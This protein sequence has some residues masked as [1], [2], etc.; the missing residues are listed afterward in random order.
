M[1]DAD[2]GLA[3]GK[4]ADFVVVAGDT[5]TEAVITQAPRTYV[6]KN[7]QVVA[8]NGEYQGKH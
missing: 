3:E 2:Y 5:V 1:K 7:G 8:S 6:V 4:Q